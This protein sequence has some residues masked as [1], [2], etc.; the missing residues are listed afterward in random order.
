M[1]DVEITSFDLR[2]SEYRLRNSGFERK[3][4]AQIQAEGIRDPLEGVDQGENRILLNGFKRYRCALKLGIGTVPYRA[5]G[6]DEITGIIELLRI[7]NRHSLGFIEQAGLV[8]EL[9]QIHGMSPGEIAERLC[10][11]K[12]WVSV[13]TGLMN[14][15]TETVRSK[16]FSGAFPVYSYMYTLRSFMRI[17]GVKKEEITRFV[18]A[19][20]GRNLSIRDIERLAYGYFNGPASFRKQ[21]LEGN[22]NWSLD[23]FRDAAQ[24]FDDCSAQERHFLRDLEILRTAMQRCTAGSNDPRLKSR[25]FYAQANLL[26]GGI[27]SQ[28][29]TFRGVLRELYDRS[30]KA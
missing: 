24:T 30:G 23:R 5:L 17:N 10:R 13:R 11:S 3:L 14:E 9:R 4:C 8:S 22:I 25:T 21:V 26:S 12:S 1:Q 27:L 7:S 15:M 2:Y 6:T 28:I 18:E 16:L 19:V 29:N 20:S